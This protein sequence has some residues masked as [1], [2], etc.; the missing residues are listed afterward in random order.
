MKLKKNDNNEKKQLK[1]NNNNAK[2]ELRTI[3]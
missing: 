2:D 1:L 3:N